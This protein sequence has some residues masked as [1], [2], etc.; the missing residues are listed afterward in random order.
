M[1]ITIR[2]SFAFVVYIHKAWGNTIYIWRP[3]DKFFLV[4]VSFVKLILV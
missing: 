4:N 2:D 3:K 1:K